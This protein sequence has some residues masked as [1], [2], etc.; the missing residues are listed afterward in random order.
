MQIYEAIRIAMRALAANKLRSVLTMLGIIIGVGAVITLMSVGRGVEKYVTDQFASAGTNLL[1]VVPG[2]LSAGPPSARASSGGTL[3][4]GDADAIGNPLQVPD[5][6]AVAPEVSGGAVVSRGKKSFRT[7]IN[8]VTPAYQDVRSWDPIIG[9]F[10]VHSDIQERGRVAVIGLQVYRRLFEPGEYPIDQ[11]IRINNLL[12]RVIGVMDERG[13]SGFG[14]LDDAVLIPFTTAQDR[15]FRRRT[16]SGDYRVNVI[17]ASVSD[18]DRMQAAQEQIADVLRERHGINYL[19]EDD[20]SIINQADLLSIFGDI[21]GALTLFLGAIAGISL[22]VGGIGIMNIMLVSVTERTREIGLRKAVGA[23]RQDILGQFLIEAITLAVLGGL[24][25][26]VLGTTGAQAISTLMDNFSAVVGLDAV[27]ISILFSMAVGLFFGI[28]PAY[29]ASRL[30]PID[31]L[32]Y[33]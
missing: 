10:L 5:V 7:N 12:F 33:E 11:T 28:Y 27:A 17:Y 4:L 6:I 14:S 20:F 2:Q 16:L 1:F 3:T 26:I 13:G 23:K 32:R 30:N 19:D 25:G 21:L 15:L 18:A 9:D 24:L 22:L 8:G 31:A 29:R